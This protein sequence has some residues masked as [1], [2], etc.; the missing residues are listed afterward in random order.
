MAE[1]ETTTAVT[2]TKVLDKIESEADSA[3]GSSNF[4]NS[5]SSFI[6]MRESGD[7]LAGGEEG[8]NIDALFSGPE[9]KGCC[10]IM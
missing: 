7:P 4:E 10:A 2:E 8:K 1:V 6:S 9:Q 3:T 5:I